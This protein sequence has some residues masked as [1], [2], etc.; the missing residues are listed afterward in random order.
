M[1][2]MTDGEWSEV[3]KTRCRNKRGEHLTEEEL[4]LV[5]RAHTSTKTGSPWGP[6][7]AFPM[8]RTEDFR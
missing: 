1:T 6:S 5:G 7:A 4:L 2:E 3:F 8:L